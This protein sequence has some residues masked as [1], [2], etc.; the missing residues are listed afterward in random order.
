MPGITAAFAIMLVHPKY[1]KKI[2][3]ERSHVMRK[4]V[5]GDL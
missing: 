5:F 4:L 2:Q 1:A 3:D